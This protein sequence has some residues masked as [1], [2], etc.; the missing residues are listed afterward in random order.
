VTRVTI[1][2]IT[3][4]SVGW[5]SVAIPIAFKKKQDVTFLKKSN[6]KTFGPETEMLK[7]ALGH[8]AKVFC[9]FFSKKKRLLKLYGCS[10]TTG[11]SR[12]LRG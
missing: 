9:F 7:P 2:S 12:S 3:N 5:A 6:K 1:V 10:V 4:V 8:L 11:S